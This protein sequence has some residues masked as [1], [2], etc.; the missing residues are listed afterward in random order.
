MKQSKKP[1]PIQPSFNQL[2]EAVSN[3]VT[4]VVVNVEMS[5]EAGPWGGNKGKSW[6]YG[7]LG[8]VEQVN[9]HV[10]NGIVQA[11]QFFYRSRDGKSA[12]SIMHGTGGDKS[13]LHRVKLD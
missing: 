8:A 2:L 1:T 4:D 3:W 9:V 10:G 13:N 12:W 7:V 11:V 5:R 6:D